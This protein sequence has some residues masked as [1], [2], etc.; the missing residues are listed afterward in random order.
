[1]FQKRLDGSIDFYLNWTDY[2]NGFGNLDG[3]FWLGL[4]KIHRLT[5]SKQYELRVY[6]E[7][8]EGNS[9][10]AEYDHFEVSNGTTKYRLSIGTY[11][12]ENSM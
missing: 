6:L 3:E 4:D 11:T 12:G 9:A 1:M 5:N 10:Y 8:W 7:D 2:K